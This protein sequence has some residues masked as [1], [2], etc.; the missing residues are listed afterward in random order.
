MLELGLE[1]KDSSNNLVN[2]IARD[3]GVGLLGDLLCLLIEL[4]LIMGVNR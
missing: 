1:A 3:S 4:T 2:N